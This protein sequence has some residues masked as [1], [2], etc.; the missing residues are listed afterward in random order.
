M[1]ALLPN[2]A[3]CLTE[4]TSATALWRGALGALWAGPAAPRQDS[5]HGPEEETESELGKP[6]AAAQS[7]G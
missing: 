1:N 5:S 7:A 2:S 6:A 4:N 3:R